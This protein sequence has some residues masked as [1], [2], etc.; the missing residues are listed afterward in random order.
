VKRREGQV[1]GFS[2]ALGRVY[3]G[4]TTAFPRFYD[5]VGSIF[6]VSEDDIIEK[7]NFYMNFR[8]RGLIL[9]GSGMLWKE[10][11]VGEMR[12]FWG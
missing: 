4:F 9:C 1:D 2:M 3:H 12:G 5:N 11:W 6:G 8:F 7:R 10:I